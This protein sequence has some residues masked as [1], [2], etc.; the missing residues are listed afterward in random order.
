MSPKRAATDDIERSD[1]RA[2]TASSSNIS[3]NVPRHD[4]ALPA[5]PSRPYAT[6]QPQQS[7]QPRG[8]ATATM[9]EVVGLTWPSMTS[10][11]RDNTLPDEPQTDETQTETQTQTQTNTQH[12]VEDADDDEE[13]TNHAAESAVART[14]PAPAKRGRWTAL[15]LDAD[16]SEGERQRRVAFNRNLADEQTRHRRELNRE[17]SRQSRQ[18]RADLIVQLKAENARLVAEAEARE[19]EAPLC[20]Q[21]RAAVAA[22]SDLQSIDDEIEE[23]LSN[24]NSEPPQQ[25]QQE[26]STPPT[27]SLAPLVAAVAGLDDLS[28]AEQ[29]PDPVAEQ[30]QDP[31]AE[32]QQDLVVEQQDVVAEPDF[33][34][35]QDD[36]L[37]VVGPDFISAQSDNLNAQPDNNLLLAGDNNLDMQL[38]DRWN[39]VPVGDLLLGDEGQNDDYH[40]ANNNTH[41]VAPPPPIDAQFQSALVGGGSGGGEAEAEGE[42]FIA[43]EDQAHVEADGFWEEF[44]EGF[45]WELGTWGGSSSF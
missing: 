27:P 14:A 4:H 21:C 5:I 15:P 9:V 36:G 40:Q 13:E 28:V 19:R 35:A 2:R 10:S 31:V 43:E 38:W 23:F 25:Q 30:Q 37:D 20:A 6:I 26:H 17:Y 7:S 12:R 33:I 42:G 44:W 22:G 18:R 1:K 8:A 41:P 11:G 45:D 29:Q 16:L 32:Q 3:G 34:S 24:L 39:N